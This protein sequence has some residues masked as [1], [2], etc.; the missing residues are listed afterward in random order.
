MMDRANASVWR[1]SGVEAIACPLTGRVPF[2]LSKEEGSEPVPARDAE[3]LGCRERHGKVTSKEADG[4]PVERSEG[5]SRD[6]FRP[7]SSADY[8]LQEEAFGEDLCGK[9]LVEC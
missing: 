4:E 8:R 2:A 3:S 5:L 1:R 6:D 9:G 7:S